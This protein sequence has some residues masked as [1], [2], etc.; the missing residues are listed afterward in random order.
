[1]FKLRRYKISE[2]KY[3]NPLSSDSFR[4]S[5]VRKITQTSRDTR[6]TYDLLSKYDIYNK[7]LTS[8]RTIDRYGESQD[9]INLLKK[10]RPVFVT[11]ENDMGRHAFLL[12]PQKGKYSTQIEVFESNGQNMEQIADEYY[13]NVRE[14]NRKL[15]ENF[16]GSN[17]ITNTFNYQGERKSGERPELPSKT[18][19]R[20]CLTRW[21]L[22]HLNL[23]EYHDRITSVAPTGL[24][25]LAVTTSAE[26]IMETLKLVD[27][28]EHE[29]MRVNREDMLDFIFSHGFSPE[30]PVE[31]KFMESQSRV[32]DVIPKPS[33]PITQPSISDNA[34]GQVVHTNPIHHQLVSKPTVAPLAIPDVSNLIQ[35][36]RASRLSS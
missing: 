21:A 4:D 1:M 28:L 2:E 20:H 16:G 17:I 11:L 15:I 33:V 13:G 27:E 8:M 24:Y 5:M 12:L 31:T 30:G 32:K 18:C 23:R 10:D 35:Q 29:D 19:F 36:M 25:N 34:T 26:A 22:K 3:K 9:V 7:G 14:L 6:H